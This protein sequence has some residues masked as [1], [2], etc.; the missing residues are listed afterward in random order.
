MKYVAVEK[1]PAKQ[2]TGFTVAESGDDLDQ[3]VEPDADPASE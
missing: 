2:P 1:P 3:I